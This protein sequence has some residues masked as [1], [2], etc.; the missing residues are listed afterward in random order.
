VHW[1]ARAITT[2]SAWA[3]RVRKATSVRFGVHG[4]CHQC[5]NLTG[6]YRVDRP[7]A[8]QLQWQSVPPMCKT[9]SNQSPISTHLIVVES[10]RIRADRREIRLHFVD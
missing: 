7:V 2:N 3:H 5:I 6:W 4:D 1:L 9:V 8:V 10:V